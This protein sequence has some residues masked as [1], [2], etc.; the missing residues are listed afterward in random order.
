MVVYDNYRKVVHD[1]TKDVAV[2]FYLPE[3]MC[4]HC[5]DFV[6]AYEKAAD[7]LS[8]SPLFENVVLAKM[9]MFAN[10]FAPGL[11]LHAFP[12]LLVR[13]SFFLFLFSP[14][15]SLCYYFIIYFILS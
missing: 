15:L 3:E 13:F 7:L 9:D 8:S 4:K 12:A 5:V 11:N 14:F 1:H 2:L 6:N 10:Q